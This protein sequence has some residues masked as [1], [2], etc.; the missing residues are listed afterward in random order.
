MLA[1]KAAHFIDGYAVDAPYD[2]EVVQYL[3]DVNGFVVLN[4]IIGKGELQDINSIIDSKSL[5]PPRPEFPRFGSAAG[6]TRKDGSGFL[7]WG[8]PFLALL[9]EPILLSILREHLGE[10]FRLDRIYGIYLRCDTEIPRSLN[11]GRLHADYGAS[12]PHSSAKPSIYC[13]RRPYELLG[14]VFAVLWTLV[15]TGPGVGGFCCIPG[16]HRARYRVPEAIRTAHDESPWVKTVVAPAGSAIIF[17]EALLHGTAQWKAAYERRALVY[18]YAVSNL[19]WGS[20]RVTAP[21]NTDL[22]EVQKR[23]LALPGEPFTHFRPI[24]D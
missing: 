7:E 24:F 15:D 3:L 9:S 23:L 10:C 18:K 6:A 20:S 8:P 22:T 5:P 11:K 4:N 17:S 19:V 2:R 12:S 14:G 16:S 1:N 13:P 21:S